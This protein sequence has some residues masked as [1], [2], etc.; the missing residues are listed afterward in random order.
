MSRKLMV[1]LS[2]WHLWAPGQTQAETF[3]DKKETDNNIWYI[4]NAMYSL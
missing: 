4:P 3:C 1:S 2:L